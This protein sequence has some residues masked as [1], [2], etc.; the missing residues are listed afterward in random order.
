MICPKCGNENYDSAFFCH[1]CGQ[2]LRLKAAPVQAI[3]SEAG[4]ALK[5]RAENT[6]DEAVLGEIG[7][8]SGNA[9]SIL[10]PGRT[11]VNSVKSFFKGFTDYG[12]NQ[13][14]GRCV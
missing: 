11:F 6:L 4:D 3:R 9:G 7:G 8:I 2:D 12:T 13:G 5:M 1:H 10:G 14:E